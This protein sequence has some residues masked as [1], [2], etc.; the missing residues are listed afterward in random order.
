MIALQPERVRWETEEDYCEKLRL[1]QDEFKYGRRILDFVELYLFDFLMCE[2]DIAHHNNIGVILCF[3]HI[4]IP[5]PS[6][7]SRFALQNGKLTKVIVV[8]LSFNGGLK[9]GDGY[10]IF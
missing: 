5:I 4:I 3:S 7:A 6:I 1:E 2:S 10:W 9:T 8:I